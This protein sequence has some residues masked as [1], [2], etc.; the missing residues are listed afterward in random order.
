M[1]FTH[2]DEDHELMKT[3]FLELK[4]KV[5]EFVIDRITGNF[6][7]NEWIDPKE[8]GY[9]INPISMRGSCKKIDRAIE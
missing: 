4:N 7:I 1:K 3:Q 9:T 2:K 6:D 8:N 5:Q